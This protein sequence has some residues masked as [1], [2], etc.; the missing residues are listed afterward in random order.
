MTV[1]DDIEQRARERLADAERRGASRKERLTLGAAFREFLKHP[2]PWM[3]TGSGLTAWILRFAHGQW[4]WVDALAP[5]ILVAAFPLIEWLIHVF[6]LHWRPRRVAG[7]LLD[8]ELASKHRAHHRDPRS[9]PLIFIPWRSLIVVIAS[10]WA[11]ALWVFPR[12]GAG[13]TFA[14]CVGIL[15]IGYEWMHYLIHS[16]YLPKSATYKS[17][18]RAH[19][20]HHYRNE[21][22]WF[23]VTTTNTADRLLGTL[24]KD[25]NAV[26]KSPT[27]KN[28]HATDTGALV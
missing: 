23:T 17:I 16:D 20:L 12:L 11:I 14:G 21:H 6:I 2:S 8:Y 15:M 22:Y 19:R 28:L 27:A 24:P 9:L 25:A 18:W 3:I 7:M 4:S 10:E 26:P 1:P 13:L 5:A